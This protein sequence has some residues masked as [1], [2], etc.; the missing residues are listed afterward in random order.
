MN[1]RFRINTNAYNAYIKNIKAKNKSLKCLL[2]HSKDLYLSDH[3][4]YIEDIETI[5]KQIHQIQPMLAIHCR[6]CG[7]T[8]FINAGVSNVIEEVPDTDGDKSYEYSK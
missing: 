7:F 2:C 4:F 1:E 3:I 8:F 6:D 5:N